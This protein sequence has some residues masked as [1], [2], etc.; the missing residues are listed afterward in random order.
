MRTLACAALACCC[1]AA[2]ATSAAAAP[3]IQLDPDAAGAQSRLAI[4]AQ[5]SDSSGGGG[6][7]AR[8][9]VLSAPRGL[10]VDPRSRSGRCSPDQAR[11][12]ACPES[13]R[14]G[15]GE[16]KGHASGIVVPGGRQDFTATIDGFLASPKQE[17]DIAGVVLQFQEPQSGQRGTA[18]GRIVPAGGDGP[19]GVELRFDDLGGSQPQYPG[20]TVT[21]DRITLEVGA[22]RTVVRKRR[23]RRHGRRVT[24]R[25]RH[26]YSLL[27]NPP[28]CDGGSWP[29][30]VTTVYSDRE[31]SQD[32]TLACTP[33]S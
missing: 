9:V 1:A 3:S 10:K 7:D 33:R 11:D 5:P 25:R 4:D 28:A 8:A 6:G 26:R 16:A 24:V 21:I 27:T 13:S 31:E 19:F 17:G 20:V 12:F 23:V 22:R 14:I 2:P 15:H 32:G 29:F 30:R 18:T